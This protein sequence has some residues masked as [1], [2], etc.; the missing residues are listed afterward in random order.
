MS[1]NI[2]KVEI[3]T[4]YWDMKFIE[5]LDGRK[6]SI[7]L[8]NDSYLN[9]FESLVKDDAADGLDNNKEIIK[10]F[11]QIYSSMLLNIMNKN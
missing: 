7:N 5:T 8:D 9:P 3:D 6:I 11:K 4:E 2:Y 1:N 10:N